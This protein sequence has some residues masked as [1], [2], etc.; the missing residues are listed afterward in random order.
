MATKG[1]EEMIG[2]AVTDATFRAQLLSD[3]KATL[4][5]EGYTVAP[6]VIAKLEA[7]DAAAAE[8]AAKDLEQKFGDLKTGW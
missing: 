8:A 3:P 6:E 2:R 7:I 5:K 4:A 1:Y